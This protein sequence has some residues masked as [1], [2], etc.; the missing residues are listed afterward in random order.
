MAIAG[1]PV[2][3]EISEQL[4]P[5][6]QWVMNL[7]VGQ[8]ADVTYLRHGETKSAK[9][10][11]ELLQPAL[12]DARE[13]KEWG[14]AGRDITRMMALERHREGTAGV[15]IDSVRAGGSAANAKLPLEGDDIITQVA[16]HKVENLAQLKKATAD[17]L[18][19]KKTSRVPVLVEFDRKM[20]HLVT[21]VKVGREEPRSDAAQ[22]KKPWSSLATQVITSDLAE[23]LGMKGKHGVRVTE[24][25]QGQAGDKA[26]FKVG[27]I[28]LKVDG[29]PLE[30]AQS[31][32]DGVFELMIRRK[33]IGDE[34][35][36]DIL[37][38]GKPQTIK[39]KLEAPMQAAT[40]PAAHTDVDFEFSTR[41]LTYQDRI[42][43]QL[44]AALHGVIITKVENGGWASLGGLRTDDIVLE[45]DGKPIDSIDELKTILS[46]IR[47]DKPRRTVFLI[48][49]GIHSRFCEI[50]PDY[51]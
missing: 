14:L 33:S 8:L 4:P 39:M 3:A 51:H 22:S 10:K 45:V 44:P 34:M 16:G 48:R 50:E 31:E 11:T 46:Q 13:L 37:R 17:I 7:P 32:D 24:V 6:N 20:K 49:R 21:I 35:A 38:D 43:Q 42:V 30:V 25:Y 9:L 5:V 26:G 1:K 12:G 2:D 18:A 23:P 19:E 28:I 15:L 41:D 47:K 40:T 36:F 27:D 29:A